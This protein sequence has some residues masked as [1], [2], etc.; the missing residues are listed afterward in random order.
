MS[1]SSS[2]PPRTLILCTKPIQTSQTSQPPESTPQPYLPH[3]LTDLI[4]THHLRSYSHDPVY[5]WTTLRH[6]TRYRCTYLEAHF[7]RFWLPKLSITVYGKGITR[8]DY[9]LWS[10]DKKAKSVAKFRAREGWSELGGEAREGWSDALWR[11]YFPDEN[12]DNVKIVLRLGVGE[13]TLNGGFGGAWIVSDTEIQDLKNDDEGRH[14]WFDW[15]K[16]IDALFREESLMRKM[17]EK[18]VQEE[19]VRLK[20]S[21]EWPVYPPKQRNLIVHFLRTQVC[22]RRKAM[23]PAYREY[24]SQDENGVFK[25][26]AQ[27]ELDKIIK[28]SFRS[29]NTATATPPTIFEVAYRE[30]SVVFSLPG[31]QF[32]DLREI[33]RLRVEELR[34]R[35]KYWDGKWVR[36]HLEPANDV[37]LGWAGKREVG[38]KDLERQLMH[39][40]RFGEAVGSLDPHLLPGHW[41]RGG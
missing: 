13:E 7:L 21:R 4:L 25:I 19:V 1:S 41:C 27:V 35:F 10:V 36:R 32:L 38:E 29:P 14:V 16:V 39:C 22:L 26:P 20:K 31:W 9:R 40:R 8:V 23:L 34:W 28:I 3:E 15:K 30:T 12:G 2:L 5:Q 6:I 24:L 17:S 33:A 37:L 11:A 18:W